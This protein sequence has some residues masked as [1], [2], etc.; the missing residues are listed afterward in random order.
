MFLDTIMSINQKNININGIS[1]TNKY[2][3][4]NLL[5]LQQHDQSQRCQIRPVKNRQ[6]ALERD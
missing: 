2:Q 3:K 6:K 4:S 5:F 1:Q